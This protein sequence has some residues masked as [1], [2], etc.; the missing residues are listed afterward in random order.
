MIYGIISVDGFLYI[1]HLEIVH[2]S[3]AY[4]HVICILFQKIYIMFMVIIGSFQV[5]LD[6]DIVCQSACRLCVF[7]GL[8]DVHD[9][10]INHVFFPA[11]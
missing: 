5:K 7:P 2:I 10:F 11:G 4:V 3:C 6:L 8:Q 9:T 1:S